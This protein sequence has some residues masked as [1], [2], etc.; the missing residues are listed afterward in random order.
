M[1]KRPSPNWGGRRPGAGRKPVGEH[2][3]VPHR[4]RPQFSGRT[5]VH[6]VLRFEARVDLRAARVRRVIE[7]SLE[8]GR[9]RSG[10]HV[11]EA[12]VKGDQLHLLAEAEGTRALSRGTQG[13]TIRIARGINRLDGAHGRVYSDHFEG[14]VLRSAAEVAAARAL[15][16][17]LKLGADALAAPRLRPFTAAW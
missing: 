7:E 3:G 6:L 15:G 2:A 12:R 11:V 9:G 8:E 1:K 4:A 13:L 17:G 14:F 16:R 10:L 5:A